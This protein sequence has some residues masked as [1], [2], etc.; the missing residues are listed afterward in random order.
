M[1]TPDG[2]IKIVDFGIARVDGDP[3]ATATPAYEVLGTAQYL[4]PEQ[5][6]GEMTDARSD[7]YSAGCLLYE[8][9]TGRPPFVGDNPAAVAYQR[10]HEDPRPA[11]TYRT[12]I[13]PALDAVLRTALA[14]DRN[15]RFPS[16]RSFREAL[17]ATAGNRS[18]PERNH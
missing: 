6:R 15:D 12:G 16:A 13:A 11:G 2:G 1:V 14:R 18:I 7:L 8:L 9:L 5:V 3:G 17:Q 10:V 4:S